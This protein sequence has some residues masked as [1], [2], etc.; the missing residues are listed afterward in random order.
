MRHRYVGAVQHNGTFVLLPASR[1]DSTRKLL[2][3]LVGLKGDDVTCIICQ[4]ERQCVHVYVYILGRGHHE[5]SNR[6]T[7][8]DEEKPTSWKF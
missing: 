7:C 8:M 3:D 1:C 6:C 4:N 5:L 2:L